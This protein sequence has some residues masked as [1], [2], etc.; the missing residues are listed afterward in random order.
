MR[1]PES[2]KIYVLT[3]ALLFLLINGISVFQQTSAVP[4]MIDPVNISNDFTSYVEI[5]SRGEE[6]LG[7][8]SWPDPPL[9]RIQG[10][11]F[12]ERAIFVHQEDGNYLDDMLFC[13][14]VPA[15]VHWEGGTRFDS[16]IISDSK[17]REN[18]NLIGDYSE[19][20]R[21][22]GASPDIDYIGLVDADRKDDLSG[23]F[24]DVNH[25]NTVTIS[26]DVY[27]GASD[28]ARYY[29]KNR[30]DMNTKQAVIA[31]VPNPSGGIEIHSKLGGPDIA[32]FQIDPI[33]DATETSWIRFGIEWDDPQ[34]DT[35]YR[36]GIRDPY[37]LQ[38]NS[39]TNIGEEGHVN[40]TANKL[41]DNKGQMEIGMAPYYSYM[42]YSVDD[43]PQ[44]LTSIQFTGTLPTGDNSV[45]PLPD[46][47]DFLSYQFGP[48]KKGEWIAVVTNWT[49]YDVNET[50]YRDFNSYIYKP[51]QEVGPEYHLEVATNDP[52]Y[53]NNARNTPEMGY[54]YADRDGYYTLTVHPYVQSVGG[55]FHSTVYWGGV[56]E[57]S[58]W[59]SGQVNWGNDIID[60]EFMEYQYLS[61]EITESVTNGAVIASLNNI[62]MLY[63]A[64]GIPEEVVLETLAE[65]GVEEVIIIDPGD[66]VD[67]SG[68][69]REGLEVSHITGD[70]EVF[71]YVYDISEDRG[72]DKSLILS[73]QGGPWFSGAALGG[74]YHG[75]PVPALD[76]DE[77]RMIQ[78][79]ATTM[80]WQVIQDSTQ[81][82][83]APLNRY[84]NP[85]QA[86]MERL[87]DDIFSWLESF[88]SDYN[89]PCGD[90][91]EDGIPDNGKNWDYSDDIDVVV[92]S[93]MNAIKPIF[94]RAMSG[95]AS[96]GRITPAE[97]EVL[98]AVL[99]R[100]ML[101]W[102]IGFSQAN[103]PENPDDHLPENNHWKITGWTFNTY[104]HD[105]DIMDNDAGDQDD[106]NWCGVDDGGSNHLQYKTREDLPSYAD[107]S[108]RKSEYHTYY[109]DILKM[110]EG[111]TLL[112]SNHGHGH[113]YW[114]LETGPGFTGTGADPSDPPWG[115]PVPDN[116]FVDPPLET[117]SGWDWYYGLDNVHS[118]F[119]TYQSCQVGG[120]ALA[121]Y[122]LRL[123]GIGVIG[124]FVTR[125]LV[126]AT[127]QSDRTTEGL[128]LH[129][130]TFGEAHRW[131]Q[132][133]TG[134]IYSLK[135]PG[136]VHHTFQEE[137]Y[138]DE[139]DFRYGDTGQTMLYGDPSLR[140]LSPTLFTLGDIYIS[141]SG[142]D[143]V[144]DLRV[145]DQSGIYHDPDSIMISVD[146][147]EVFAE[148][149]DTGKY[150]GRWS[151]KEDISD[152]EVV[153]DITDEDYLSPAGTHRFV[154]HYDFSISYGNL[155]SG[156]LEYIGGL[157]QIIRSNGPACY[158]L[159][160]GEMV[161]QEQVNFII[162]NVRDIDGRFAMET[163]D[164]NFNDGDWLTEEVN[165]SRLP[166][167]EYYIEISMSI[168]YHPIISVRGLN[169]NIS[170]EL[171]F[172][173]GSYHIDP[174]SKDFILE[175]LVIRSTYSGHHTVTDEELISGTYE[176][177]YLSFEG[178][179]GTIMEGEIEYSAETGSFGFVQSME[180]QSVGNYRFIINASTEYTDP[181]YHV[182][183]YFFLEV[184]LSISD[185]SIEYLGGMTQLLI[186]VDIGFRYS[187]NSEEY[188]DND[189][190]R[191]AEC[192]VLYPDH[193][194]TGITVPLSRDG[195][196][197]GPV[198]I[199]VS[200]LKNGEYLVRMNAETWD[201]GSNS[202]ISKPFS[203]EHEL[204]ISGPDIKYDPED[205]S[206][207]LDDIRIISSCP[208][209]EIHPAS[210]YIRRTYDDEFSVDISNEV[211]YVGS[212]WIVRDL[213]V[214]S[215]LPEG[216]D[217]YI[218]MNFYSDGLSTRKISEKFTVYY[219]LSV[220]EP[221]ISYDRDN[222]LLTISDII[223]YSAYNNGVMLESKDMNRTQISI[224]NS[225]SGDVI[226][227]FDL[228]YLNGQFFKDITTA[229]QRYGEGAVYFEL[230]VSTRLSGEYIFRL[231]E[232]YLSPPKHKEG[233]NNP[234]TGNENDDGGIPTE[235]IFLLVI[236]GILSIVTILILTAF[237]IKKRNEK[238]YSSGVEAIYGGRPSD[239][240]YTPMLYE[241]VR[242]GKIEEPKL[243]P[244]ERQNPNLPPKID[245]EYVRPD[246]NRSR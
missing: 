234:D 18:G 218:I 165:V 52:S 19:Y 85:S 108:G 69:V 100:E 238:F 179:L 115:S 7:S 1:I 192:E 89:P 187:A 200:F 50:I 117:T 119:S 121:E 161:Q 214:M 142:E 233:M 9:N 146:G 20:L 98:W 162:L 136:P 41:F 37:A 47:T 84:S 87:S 235:L 196:G 26:D 35:D 58:P 151:L 49:Y 93:P 183:D 116:G 61:D 241:S 44:E 77:A 245:M 86:N 101:Y 73:A 79:Q 113:T 221:R 226:D 185:F 172:E 27:V 223:V 213:E 225:T 99:N 152:L 220:S 133:E 163:V 180:M 95:K 56:D 90:I 171:Y 65:I 145:M 130:M 4:E 167:G 29:W 186:V 160:Y 231:P 166:A 28:I 240:T 201:F 242:S 154:K 141:E 153:I 22:T 53:K 55:T 197:W 124:G 80:W 149:V 132:D 236:I 11:H 168:R 191:Y 46:G 21:K 120:S 14:A 184:P 243:I 176:F 156:D 155:S 210:A 137:G 3:I 193:S 170:H 83:K 33:V 8:R 126:E 2:T 72:L 48:V 39:Y 12:T 174:G 148:K 62:P 74:A 31:Y 139:V 5:P 202:L 91:N 17:N 106:D 102:K 57:I 244:A 228:Y 71:N 230:V 88:N 138:P 131:G 144:I 173:E 63:T 109:D 206:L 30:R 82:N 224:Y 164:L 59:P 216:D 178:Y 125:S 54:C 60:Y 32:Q 114:M 92:I 70:K 199:N 169:F 219:D 75:A 128:L 94:D 205:Y 40:P 181:T 81:F 222:D 246:Y 229:I 175:D 189:Q 209:A 177:Q 103:N 217:Y 38:S 232:I 207:D 215:M 118:S 24:N 204:S 13:A 78:I 42:P 122:Y 188:I 36:I 195:R 140:I 15:A 43:D 157:K 134:C 190:V 203:V 23:Y 6:T 147:I 96:V 34:A 123:G 45:W 16:M 208:D 104:A 105:D 10:D 198:H 112:W 110:L 159:L 135:D 76:D 127:I 97:P 129:N 150:T 25:I 64:G 66:M 68:W 194:K 143:L 227:Q 158:P 237:V 107:S 182:S 51:D 111:G 67:K 212:K 239:Q 211:R